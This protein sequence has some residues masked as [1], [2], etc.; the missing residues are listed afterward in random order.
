MGKTG[1]LGRGSGG[2]WEGWGSKY[3]TSHSP[4][5]VGKTRVLNRVG[6][7]WSGVC[8]WGGGLKITFPTALCLEANVLLS[9]G[10]N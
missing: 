2:G 5:S 6:C 3:H 4:V 7:W 8:V 1:V 10:L 9:A